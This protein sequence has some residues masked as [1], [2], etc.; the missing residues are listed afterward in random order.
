MCACACEDSFVCVALASVCSNEC[1]WY[2]CMYAVSC[3]HVMGVYLYMCIQACLC[4]SLYAF[5]SY[6]TLDVSLDYSLFCS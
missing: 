5:E 3:A 2:T 6:L 1:I 4:A